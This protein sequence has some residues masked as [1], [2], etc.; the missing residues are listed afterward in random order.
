MLGIYSQVYCNMLPRCHFDGW[1]VSITAENVRCKP[2]VHIF[3]QCSLCL[4]P[5]VPLLPLRLNWLPKVYD[6]AEFFA[7]EGRLTA[8]LREAKYFGVGLD[9]TD[10]GGKAMDL[11]TT[12]GMALLWLQLEV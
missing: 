12:A 2:I 1:H 11:T 4:L 5:P 8:S 10:P 9:I 6:F 3:L 7:G